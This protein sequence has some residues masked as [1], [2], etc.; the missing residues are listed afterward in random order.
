M[1]MS[2]HNDPTL[3]GALNLFPMV[4]KLE[5]NHG[6]LICFCLRTG[7]GADRFNG[8][9]AGAERELANSSNISA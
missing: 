6:R 9:G 7:K 1:E 2:R 3:P 8:S 5:L 4:D